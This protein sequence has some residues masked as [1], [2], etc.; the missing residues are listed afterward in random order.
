MGS[1][2]KRSE[3]SRMTTSRYSIGLRDGLAA[4]GFGLAGY[5]PTLVRAIQAHPL[6]DPLADEIALALDALQFLF[7]RRG[8]GG[9]TVGTLVV[10]AGRGGEAGLL[11]YGFEQVH[12]DGR[13]VEA[14]A[15]GHGGIFGAYVEAGL[16]I[17]IAAA[18]VAAHERVE[19]Q[20]DRVDDAGAA[21][22]ILLERDD[23]A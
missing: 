1:A 14:G 9:L 20:V 23:P 19:D 15:G 5:E 12:F 6:L 18:E 11:G 17:V 7:R 13:A 10:A 3:R 4:G 16:L 8:V 2:L 21:A 22:E